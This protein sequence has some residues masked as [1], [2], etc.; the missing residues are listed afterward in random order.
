VIVLDA[1]AAVELLLETPAG[2]RVAHRLLY[3]T[4]IAPHLIDVEVAHVVRR[5]VASREVSAADGL[6]ALDDLRR[7][8][9]AR[10]AHTALLDRV[11]QLRG[12]LTA[13]DACYIA[14][15]EM[16]RAPLITFDA[17][18]AATTGHSATVELIA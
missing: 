11:W 18:L 4:M 1:S 14:L 3:Q 16:V 17:R 2:S 15:A 5:R 8:K 9:L 13:Y 7:L 6:R 12:Q 10:Y